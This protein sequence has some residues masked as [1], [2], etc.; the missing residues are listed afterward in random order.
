M[1]RLLA[2][3]AD[4]QVNSQEGIEET[5]SN[6]L[7]LIRVEDLSSVILELVLSFPNGKRLIAF[8]TGLWVSLFT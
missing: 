8:S 4:T 1:S 6:Y 7:L 2:P 5:P 3:I